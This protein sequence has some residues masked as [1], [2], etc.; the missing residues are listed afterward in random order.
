MLLSCFEVV[1][2]GWTITLL[3]V[4]GGTS[5]FFLITLGEP[6]DCFFYSSEATSL[7]VWMSCEVLGSLSYFLV[8]RS[9]NLTIDSLFS[10]T[11][12]S[13]FFLSLNGL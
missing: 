4:E 1:G 5:H 9:F 2:E 13:S 3:L 6:E 12:L 8:F 11:I 10:F 7:F